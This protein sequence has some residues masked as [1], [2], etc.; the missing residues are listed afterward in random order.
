[1]VGDAMLE[2]G[3]LV[4]QLAVW[5]REITQPQEGPHDEHAHGDGARRVQDRRGHDGAVFREHP[6]P[7]SPAA[8][9]AT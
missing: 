9:R 4:R 8:V 2:F 7:R 6:R 5:R 1:M 3:E